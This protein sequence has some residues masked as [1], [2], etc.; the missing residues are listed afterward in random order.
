MLRWSFLI[1]SLLLAGVGLAVV[2]SGEALAEDEQVLAAEELRIG[3]WNIEQLGSPGRRSRPATNVAQHPADL[4]RHILEARVDVLAL[5]EIGDTDGVATT[6]TNET[7]DKT[8]KILNKMRGQQWAYVLFPKKDPTETYQLT[9]VMW[10]R[11]RV[12]KVGDPWKIPV[13]DDPSDAFSTWRRH[14]HALMLSAGDGKT[15]F[16]LVSVHM[17]SNFGG[18]VT[19]QQR[20]VEARALAAQIPRIQRHFGD[21]DIV[22][23]GD[24]NCLSGD[25]QGVTNYTPAGLTDLN[26]RDMPTTWK[27]GS[28]E[29]AP[30]DRILV[31]TGQP[32]FSESRMAVRTPANDAAHIDHKKRLSDHHVVTT[33]IKIMADDDKKQPPVAGAV[34]NANGFTAVT[35]TQ[36]SAEWRMATRQ[37]YRWAT[38]QLNAGLADPSW[39]ADLAQLETGDYGG[40]PPAIILDVDDTVLDNSPH[41][42]RMLLSAQSSGNGSSGNGSSGNGPLKDWIKQRRAAAIPGAVAFIGFARRAGVEVFF[43]TNRP[44]QLKSA[45]IG[46]LKN[47]GIAVDK[48]HVLTRNDAAGRG[49]DKVSRRAAVAKDHRIVLLVGDNL[50]D[51]CSGMNTIDQSAR[52][53]RAMR[54]EN[55][56]GNRWVLIPNAIYGGWRRPLAALPELADA[57]RPKLEADHKS[58]VRIVRL[59]PN[60]VGRDDAAESVTIRNLGQTEVDLDG[61]M[62]K[63]DDDQR[64]K[65]P[66]RGEL[67]PGQEIVFLRPEAGIQLSNG[68]DTIRLINSAGRTVH[69]VTYRGPVEAGKVVVP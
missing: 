41:A 60:P 9:G 22:I 19:Q 53:Q 45:T 16:V 15:D 39:S 52:N 27:G 38:L 56:L 2:S 20:A 66:L 64:L 14:P 12:R 35:W 21:K 65:W 29:P 37:A 59:V 68:G 30:F 57:L 1:P 49:E 48:R 43:V 67:G 7:I 23:L 58:R 17:K 62:L 10:N 46:N 13:M 47:V 50:A 8:L 33:V 54:H 42:A 40:K 28:Y 51:L 44:D 6:Q 36:N 32:E 61:W 3:S 24:F 25:E 26:A 11:K 4:A 34:E 31:P 63:D 69:E 5:Q 55:M 18:A